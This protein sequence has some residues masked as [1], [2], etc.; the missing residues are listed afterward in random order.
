[1]LQN[2][3]R[4]ALVF[5]AVLTCLVGTVSSASAV[6]FSSTPDAQQSWIPNGR[7]YDVLTV[8]D[9]V[10]I[11]G[12]FSR[13][14]N[15]VTGQSAVRNRLAAFDRTTGVLLPWDPG[16]DSTVRTMAAGPDGTIYVGGRLTS[17]G[18]VS[19]SNVVAISAGGNGLESFRTTTSGE[20]R[21]LLV[22]DGGLF[23][24]G[25][26]GNVNGASRVGVARVETDTGRLVTGFNARLGAG[27]A[28]ALDRRPDGGLV[29]GGNFKTVGGRAQPFLAHVST[30]TG[31]DSGMALPVVCDSCAVLDLV[32]HTDGRIYAAVAGGGGRVAAWDDAN[33]YRLW[34]RRGDGDVQAIDV[35]DGRVYAGGHFGPGFDD[36]ERHQFAL[37]D[38]ASGA[39]LDMT[40]PFTGNDKPG[41]WAVDVDAEFLRLGGGFAGVT[42][43]SA[44]RYATFR[45][46]AL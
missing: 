29:V 11:G 15:P 1:M 19:G 34:V 7:V 40:I 25:S 20:V 14:R 31:A 5:V 27:R 3:R 23:V 9:R 36:V 30:V 24:A 21:D 10:Y 22:S 2:C 26:F 6:D 32:S 42:G 43:S 18:G 13:V 17:A 33:G 39:L 8:G 35:D 41:I 16:A 38:A 4:A 45:A 44:A 37:L 46:S 12:T 28:F